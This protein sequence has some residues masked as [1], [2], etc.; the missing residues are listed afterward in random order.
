MGAEKTIE[1]GIREYLEG[2]GYQTYKIHVGQYGPLGFPDLLVIKKG[3]TS[4]FEVK[5]TGKEP[6][7]IQQMR[8]RDLREAGCIVDVV[9]SIGDALYALRKEGVIWPE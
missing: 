8:I 6:E 9:R 7:K 4:Y 3:I 5:N 2:L 1:T